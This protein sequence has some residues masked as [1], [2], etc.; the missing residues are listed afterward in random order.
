MEYTT[1]VKKSGNSLIIRI[2]KEIKKL[3]KLKEGDIL[4]TRLEKIKK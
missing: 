2:P 1:F 3:M 4:K